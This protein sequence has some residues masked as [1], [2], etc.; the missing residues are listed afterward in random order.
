MSEWKSDIGTERHETMDASE[1][2]APEKE[3]VP[4]KSR[5]V[6]R[7]EVLL[8]TGCGIAGLVA[9]GALASWGVT[10][11]SIASGRLE[12]SSTPTKMIVTDRARCS[13]CQ[14]C[15]MMCTLR[16]DGVA[17]QATARVRVGDNYQYG[18]SVDT[19]DGIF[20]NCQFT[21][22]TCKQCEDAQC[23]KYCP[24][25]AIYADPETGARV[26]DAEVCIGCGMCSAAC[27][28]GM[29]VVDDTKGV[30]TKCISCGRCAE[31]CPNG[32]ITFIDWED[33]AQAC[34]DQGLVSSV[35]ATTEAP[36]RSAV[37]Y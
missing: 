6:T 12:I 15:E 37:V 29:P 33:I 8:A 24:V 31:Q 19:N 36:D 1:H 34:I 26:V 30:S 13:G 16:N 28:W 9:G 10:S 17:R 7:R 2:V 18:S 22:K 5:K 27:P 4:A 23:A 14:R 35:Y 3:A 25:H 32:A 20:G 11:A 21:I